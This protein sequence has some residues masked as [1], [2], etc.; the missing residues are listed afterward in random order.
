[1][2][3]VLINEEARAACRRYVEANNIQAMV[4]MDMQERMKF[5]IEKYGKPV[6]PNNGRNALK[7]AYEE[8]LDLA[9]YLKQRLVEEGNNGLHIPGDVG[10]TE[11]P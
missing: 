6:T 2:K 5:G 4:I 8:V 9:V 7:D 3:P 1:M 11:T 10:A